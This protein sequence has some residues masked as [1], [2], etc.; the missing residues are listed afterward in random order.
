MSEVSQDPFEPFLRTVRRLPSRV[1]RH[2][3]QGS[4]KHRRRG[5]R[6]E[7]ECDSER[8]RPQGRL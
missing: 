7:N 4:A 2:D 5:I 8:G 6:T 1:T 3:D